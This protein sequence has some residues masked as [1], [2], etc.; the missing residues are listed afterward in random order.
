MDFNKKEEYYQEAKYIL[1]IVSFP[2]IS[3]TG[4]AGRI[5]EGAGNQLAMRSTG[6]A[7]NEPT[8]AD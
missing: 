3:Q 1:L 4:K 2:F 5:K 6:I 7:S 8:I